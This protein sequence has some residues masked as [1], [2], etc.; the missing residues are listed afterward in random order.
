[1]NLSIKNNIEKLIKKSFPDGYK[2][3]IRR[4]ILLLFGLS[5][6]GVLFLIFFSLVNFK[7]QNNLLGILN[8]VTA[9]IL[10]L[11]LFDLLHRKKIIENIYVG[12]LVISLLYLYSFATGGVNNTAFVWYFTYPLMACYLMGSK[13]GG[14]VSCLMLL[15]AFLLTYLSS[16]LIFFASYSPSFLVR[17]FGAYI[18]IG[19]FSY[20]FERT[21]EK[22]Q[23]ELDMLNHS[24]ERLVEL[25]TEELKKANEKLTN[26]IKK[27]KVI[28]ERLR[29]A[30]K[31]E[32]IGVLAG[33]IAHDFNNI[34]SPII[35]YSEMLLSDLPKD[36]SS[37]ESVEYIYSSAMRAKELVRQILTFSRQE[38]DEIKPMKLEPVV[39]EVIK[40]V[41]ATLPATI[42][43]HTQ[44]DPDCGAINANSTH[45]H[46]LVMNVIT[47]AY[48]AIGKNAGK[49]TVRLSKIKITESQV[50][51][52]EMF[53]GDY[54]CLSISD[55]GIGMDK[56]TS[57]RISEPFYTTKSKGQGTGMGLSVVHGIVKNMGGEIEIVSH[58]DKGS[59]FK[60]YF[61]ALER[62]LDIIEEKDDRFIRNGIE[63]IMLVD[64]ELSIISMVQKYLERLGYIVES[65]SNP[66]QAIDSFCKN[67]QRFDLV[68]TD[69]SMPKITG[70][71]LAKKILMCRGDIPV[72]LSTGFCDDVMI[73]SSQEI[74][75]KKIL[76]KPFVLNELS[77]QIRAVLDQ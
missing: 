33:G 12:V 9:L 16:S 23:R 43:I 25:R 72:I 22:N 40:L 1:M 52:P 28:E 70:D 3:E 58:P 77:Q 20:L 24:L 26:D 49:I 75:I 66:Q 15:A 67:P 68:I 62:S 7:Q 38:K 45:M 46:Q 51:R 61:P 71:V 59:E 30:E 14:I 56:A 37:R 11:N 32:A 10:I 47:N 73:S 44:I 13:K 17:F 27:R 2:P 64:D 29:K 34:L 60:F 50:L 35:G 55:S 6:T 65:F 69:F 5:L 41:R 76:E 31:M 57:Q 4:H 42:D 19:L 48:H 39:R 53:S 36:N 54:I 74:G 18:L 8:L 63:R 21:R